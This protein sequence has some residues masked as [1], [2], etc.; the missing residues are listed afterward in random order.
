MVNHGETRNI[1]FSGALDVL[2]QVSQELQPGCGPIYAFV[3]GGMAVSWWLGDRRVSYDVDAIFSHRF[4]IPN[5]SSSIVVDG[6]KR[7]VYFDHNFNDTFSL[8][9]QDYPDRAEEVGRFGELVVKVI[10][11]VDLAIM[12]CSRFTE[13]DR[14]DI[15]L[16]ISDGLIDREEF[17]SLAQDAML[18]YVGNLR[19]IEITLGVIGRYFEEYDTPQTEFSCR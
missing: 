5:I 12:K 10:A 14:N 11:P 2:E 4:A 13:K 7:T 15:I 16:M 1:V 9:Q 18:D 8:L 19:N 6:E 17:F 3:A